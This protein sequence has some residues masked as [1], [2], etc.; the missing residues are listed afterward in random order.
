[1]IIPYEMIEPE[2]LNR[3]IEE[4]VSREG[5]DNGYEEALSMR[6]AQVLFRLKS[7]DMVIVFDQ[8]SQTPNILHKDVA[9]QILSEQDV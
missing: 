8:E 3:L 9:T 4:F 2:A 7:G 5:T 6:V 1:M